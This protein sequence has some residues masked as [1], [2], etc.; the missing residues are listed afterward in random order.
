MALVVVF[1]VL[2]FQIKNILNDRS[3]DTSVGDSLLYPYQLS[4]LKV[5]NYNLSFLKFDV[6]S[7]VNNQT[8]FIKLNLVAESVDSLSGGVILY[9]YNNIQWGEKLDENNIGIVDHSDLTSI[10]TIYSIEE[11]SQLQIDIS[12]IIDHAESIL[13]H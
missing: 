12:N 11:E 13:L 5:N 2:L 3:V 9:Q 4:N 6:P 1:G 8:Y 10:D 7:S